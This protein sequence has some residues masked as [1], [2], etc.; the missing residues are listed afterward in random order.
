MPQGVR[1]KSLV[2][3]AIQVLPPD[4]V[5]LVSSLARRAEELPMSTLPVLHESISHL[6]LSSVSIRRLLKNSK[7]PDGADCA[8]RVKVLAWEKS[9]LRNLHSG[10]R[11]LVDSNQVGPL[12]LKTGI[13]PWIV[14]LPD[15][16][17]IA[18][19]LFRMNLP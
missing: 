14:R 1:K 16:K 10:G 4:P 9:I 8:L 15:E 12:T 19:G 2:A 13:L 3:M 17:K 11:P 18:L 5:V 6:I 7:Q